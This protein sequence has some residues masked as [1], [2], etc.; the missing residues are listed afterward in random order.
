MKT[1]K[2]YYDFV[3]EYALFQRDRPQGIGIGKTL[4][5]KRIALM[6]FGMSENYLWKVPLKVLD[7]IIKQCERSKK[8]E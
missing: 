7:Y 4:F 8:W 1:L 6:K 5:I 3:D 2:D